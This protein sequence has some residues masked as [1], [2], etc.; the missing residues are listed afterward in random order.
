MKHIT[1]LGGF[2]S[3]KPTV[4]TLGKFDGVHRGHRKLLAKVHEIARHRGYDAAVFTFSVSPQVQMGARRAKMLMTNG[5]RAYF[6]REQ[7]ID[8]LVECPFTEEIRTMEAGAFA[9]QI[10]IGRMNAKALVVG[11]DFRFGLNRAGTPAFLKQYEE[12]GAFTVDIIEKEKDTEDGTESGAGRDI[13][14]TYIREELEKGRMEKVNSLLGYPYFIRG[15]IVHG[16]HLGHTLGFPTINQVP[17]P[18][19]MLPPNGVYFSRTRVGGKW[20]QGVSN[21]GVKPTVNG[22]A[23]GIETYLFDCSLDL[24]GQT[25]RVE[26]LSFRRPEMRFASIDA[27]KEQMERDIQAADEYFGANT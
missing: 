19:K 27:L 17:D 24:Y 9:E 15:G 4:V 11:T 2:V 8:L 13:S 7:N 20:Y 23:M 18:E 5:E 12:A 1:E 10:L 22:D 14:S 16:R 26:L 6:L 21:V 25:A 3:E